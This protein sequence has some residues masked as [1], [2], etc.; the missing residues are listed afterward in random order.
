MDR[1]AH[2]EAV[3]ASKAANEVSWYQQLPA[4]S[5]RLFAELHVKTD[6]SIIDVGGGDSSLVDAL[7]D[8][9]YRYL[10][11]LDL[12]GAALARARARLGPRANGVNWLEADITRSVLPENAYDVWHDRAV[13]HFLTGAED[14]RHY[15]DAAATSVRPDGALIIA[16][17]APNGPA[18]C[19]GLDVRR[20]SGA[21]LARELGDA[22]ALERSTVEV[23]STPSGAQ[24]PFTYAVLRRS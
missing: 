6:S 3:Y 2:W 24:Q 17:F 7:L 9:Q 12:S 8:R 11:V 4:V 10:T 15:V 13:F 14:R 20:Y 18:R 22:F 5:L 19:S 16:T 23:H 21:S 1:K